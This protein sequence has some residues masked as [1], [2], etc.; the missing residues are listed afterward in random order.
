MPGRITLALVLG[1]ACFSTPSHKKGPVVAEGGGI[2]IT[3]DELKARIEEQSPMIRQS[4]QNLDRK[5]QFLDNLVRFEL[6]AR[7]AEKQGF[8]KDP[9]V[10][11]TMKRVMVSKYY[12][13]F[14]QDKDGAQKVSDQEVQQYYDEHKDEFHRPAKIHAAH[15]FIAAEAGS[16]ER[17]KKAAEAKKLLAR[18]LAEQPKNPGAFAAAARESSEDAA[19]KQAGGDLGFKTQ[20]EL[21]KAFDPGFAAAVAKAGD[22]EIL[23]AVLESPKGFH[24]VRVLGRQ[25]EL[26]RSLDEAKAQIAS[27]LASQKKTKEFDEFM[28]KLRD[29]AKIKVN[30]AELEKVAVAGP[31][32]PAGGAPGVPP[33]HPPHPVPAAS[34][35]APAA[36]ATPAAPA[37]AASAAAPSAPSR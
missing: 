7:E 32:A 31:M 9:E 17:A 28:K 27:R 25:P 34:P 1:L 11:F 26:N 30:D 29:D 21:E 6:L 10:L 8:A 33:G 36:P 23:P 35:V 13:R 16:P 18:M 2:T 3:A 12:Q 22:N 4:F 37:P 24:L 14:F 19:T 5:K 15:I 20:D